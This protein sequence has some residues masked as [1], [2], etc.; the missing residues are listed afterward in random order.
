VIS[1]SSAASDYNFG[2]TGI[3][4]G[5]ILD[6][7]PFSSGW[8]ASAGVRYVDI[9]LQGVARNGMEFGGISY[10]AGEI[11]KVTATVRNGNPAAPYFGIGYDS[12]HFSNDGSGFKLGVDIGAMYIGEPDVTIRTAITPA[13]PTFASDVSSTASSIKDSLRNY[14]FYPVAMLSARFSF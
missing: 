4:A 7:H 3:F 13:S 11:G 9:E 12:S 2:V 10:S 5:G 8:R 6:F 1:A 14:P